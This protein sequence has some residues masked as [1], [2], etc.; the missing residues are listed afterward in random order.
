[1]ATWQAVMVG[2]RPGPGAERPVGCHLG[3][4]QLNSAA[5]GVECG[6]VHVFQCVRR[7]L[8]PCERHF[9]VSAKVSSTV[10]IWQSHM[11]IPGNGDF[12]SAQQT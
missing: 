9:G 11:P 12:L 10:C 5:R 6:C 1:V 8:E 4:S 7:S 3:A 2:S